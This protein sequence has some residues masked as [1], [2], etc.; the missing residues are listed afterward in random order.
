MS[1]LRELDKMEEAAEKK[2]SDPNETREEFIA[3]MALEGYVPTYPADNELQI[4]LDNETH[5]AAFERSFCIL[6]RELPELI[7]HRSVSRS[8]VGQHVRIKLPF[9]VT[10]M[11]RIAWQAALG[12]D[13]VRELLSCLRCMRGDAEPTM[14]IEPALFKIDDAELL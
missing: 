4:D 7:A 8:G 3:K 9:V 13:P 1:L 2:A 14:L 5:K 11:E 10:P 12:S 6:Q